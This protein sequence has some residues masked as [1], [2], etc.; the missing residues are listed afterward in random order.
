[1]MWRAWGEFKV[2]W[3]IWAV[4]EPSRL[5]NP[6]VTRIT[7][8]KMQKVM[9]SRAIIKSPR[10][11]PLNPAS[12]HALL[13]LSVPFPLVS[14]PYSTALLPFLPLAA[15][16]L[17]QSI[18]L[19]TTT[20][21]V[22]SRHHLSSTTVSA[23]DDWA[24]EHF[25]YSFMHS[26]SIFARFHSQLNEFDENIFNSTSL[27]SPNRLLNVLIDQIA[28]SID[29]TRAKAFYITINGRHICVCHIFSIAKAD[30][31]I[32]NTHRRRALLSPWHI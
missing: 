19:F 24:F 3:V 7:A 26:R 8:Q 27:Q 2:L 16:K 20:N 15:F 22:L 29:F 11:Y 12:L 6:L 13:L 17:T 30:D 31:I 32:T 14:L 21:Q 9:Q 4:F 5:H 23:H 25:F 10:A 1:M 18:F 28:L